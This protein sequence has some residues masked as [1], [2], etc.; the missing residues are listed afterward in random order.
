MPNDDNQKRKYD[1]D[2]KMSVQSINVL[3]NTPK[4]KAAYKEL[5]FKSFYPFFLFI[6]IHYYKIRL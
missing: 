4:T 1:F 2:T 5:D 3:T 6:N